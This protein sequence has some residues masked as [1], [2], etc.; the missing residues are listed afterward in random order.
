M[1]AP[2]GQKT[3][4]H[5]KKV[6]LPKMLEIMLKLISVY[7]FYSPTSHSARNTEFRSRKI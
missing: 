3:L 2:L 1:G 5:S 6:F 4:D 7:G